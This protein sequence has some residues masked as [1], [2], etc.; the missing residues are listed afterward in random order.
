MNQITQ[1]RRKLFEEWYVA[2]VRENTGFEITVKE[3]EKRRGD[4]GDYIDYPAMHGK[5]VGFNGALD[6]LFIPIP[7]E[8]G[9]RSDY[10][11]GFDSAIGQVIDAFVGTGLGLRRKP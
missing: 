7:C 2:D 6:V 8:S 10:G 11:R 5:W 9:E 4:K 3:V 1:A